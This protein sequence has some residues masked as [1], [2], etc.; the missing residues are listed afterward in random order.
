MRCATPVVIARIV[1]RLKIWYLFLRLAE[2]GKLAN[3]PEVLLHYRQHLESTNHKRFH[4]Q[5]AKKRACVADAYARRGA[6]LPTGWK[7][8]PRHQLSTQEEI[9]QWAWT[10][11]KHNHLPAARRQAW[12]VLR[13]QP[14]AMSSWRLLYC[15]L[16]GW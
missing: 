7:P 10:A 13:I 9:S 8:P 6:S 5:E 12:S 2:I 14:L 1:S 16:R 15:T 4:E 3:L 11:L